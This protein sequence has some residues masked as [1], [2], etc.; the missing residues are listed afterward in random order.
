MII[1]LIR[2]STTQATI[3][4]NDRK[5]TFQ[6]VQSYYLKFCLPRNLCL[7]P[8]LFCQLET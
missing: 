8:R 1:F 6:D 3:F 4:F 2:V 5:Q 7:D